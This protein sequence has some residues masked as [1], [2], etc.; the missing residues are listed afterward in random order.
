M[1][2]KK[3]I[4]RFVILIGLVYIRCY[5]TSV[6][7][8]STDS[9]KPARQ[10][11]TSQSDLPKSIEKASLE[12]DKYTMTLKSFLQQSD[13]ESAKK[14][15]KKILQKLESYK[16]NDSTL[17][18]SF[19][20]IGTYFIYN[21]NLTEALRYLNKCVANKEKNGVFDKQYVKAIYNICVVYAK[22]GDFEN[23]EKFGL[24]SLD[25]YKKT[26][27]KSSPA[28]LNPYIATIIIM[29]TL[30]KYENAISYSDTALAIYVNNPGKVQPITLTYLYGELA[31]IFAVLGDQSKSKIYL[32]KTKSL[33]DNFNLPKRN[34]EYINLLDDIAV[35]YNGLGHAIE[36]KAAFEE[37]MKIAVTYNSAYSFNLI[38]N[39]SNFLAK[40]HQTDRGEKLLIETIDRAKPL[41][42]K[43]LKDYIELLS[44]YAT[45]LRENNVDFKKSVRLYE[46][47]HKYLKKNPHDLLLKNI[48]YFGYC[49]SLEKTGD[50]RRALEI[51]D[52]LISNYGRISR[53]DID[54][55]LG[56]KLKP[57]LIT[58]K[59]LRIKHDILIDIYKKQHDL[60]TLKAVSNT[61]ELIVKM[62]DKVRIN[63]T[64]EESRLILGDKYRNSY[65]NSISDFY[66]LYA[67]TGEPQFF[68][69]AFE[70]SEKSK[71][72]GLLTSTRELKA[73][74]FNIPPI[75][76]NY[77]RELQRR[78]SLL[79]ISISEESG[80]ETVNE[81]LV[82]RLKE[83]LLETTRS[84][85]S[86]IMIFE[87]KYPEY[88][89][90]KYNTKMTGLKDIPNLIGRNGNYINYILSDTILYTIVVNSKNQQLI[91]THI[92]STF[93]SDIKRFRSLLSMPNPS[94]NL[95]QKFKEF[96]QVGTRLYAVLIGPVKDYLIS[97]K[98]CIS[99][100]NI[101]SYIPFE[102]IPL[103]TGKREAKNYR[104][105][106]YLMNDYDISY[107]YSATLMAENIEKGYK[108]SNKLIAF[109]PNYPDPIN[110]Q[111]VMMS[112]QVGPG[113][114][115]DL[116][117]ARKEAEYVTR[118]TGGRLY[119][120]GEASESVYKNESGK[121]DIIHLA[122]HTLLNDKDPMRSTLLFS[123]PKDTIDDGYL[124]TYEV[125]GVPLKAKM[126]VLSSCNTGA[127]L[128]LSGEGIISLARGFIYSGSQSVV[129][130]MWEIEDKSGTDIVEMFYKNLK[131]GNSKSKALKKARI[132]FLKKA[133]LLRSH[134][135]Y[136]SSL[137]VYG[138]DT[139]LYYSKKLII[140]SSATAG[141]LIL[142]FGYFFW[143][144]RYS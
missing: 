29:Q 45:F 10:E 127:G 60:A 49:Q 140:I 77:E 93:F 14:Q 85:D 110:I 25:F 126:V 20:M 28:L 65:L 15:V 71:V 41:A 3:Q 59:Y 62:L 73:T 4:L 99:P 11:N 50:T 39:Y 61:S 82:G 22:N 1:L 107:T 104:D 106:N 86:L 27:G 125:Y 122:M 38:K 2:S 79:N 108:T 105:Q 24:K 137:V 48:V 23:Y 83:D 81:S 8:G 21:N 88:Y 46:E 34:D 121:Y 55:N 115:N 5:G 58:V 18:K 109:A 100:D 113:V 54:N 144:R 124:K 139:P 67:K 32:D 7:S 141:M 72:A 119:E 47:C 136:W 35:T 43:N 80:K 131:D 13:M 103:A 26:Y 134:P 40:E 132:S 138:N 128:M 76:A 53:E 123:H 84:R 133:D 143:R 111:S 74:Q 42:Q 57:D 97:D 44:Y 33:Y 142:V 89:A 112:R 101:L 66:L 36:S 19:Y 87:N 75:T 91:A 78:L 102:A 6:C 9:I 68:E 51:V 63:I 30:K 90:I 135:Y 117:Y 94:D 92:D 64:E 116:P 52:T 114:L 12:I 56:S 118:L 129:M 120:N 70:Y 17:C 69:K 98:I 31:H 130:S 96:Q 16:I 37:G 95:S